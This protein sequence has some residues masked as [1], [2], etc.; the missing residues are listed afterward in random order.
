M[1]FEILRSAVGD[2]TAARLG[3]LAFP[4]R[5]PI[6]T[7]NFFAVTSRGVVPHITPDNVAKYGHFGGAYMALED[8]NGRSQKDPKSV[9][10]I[11]STK[12]EP[13]RRLL[14]TFTSQSS[15]LVT[16]LGP[17]RIPAVK[18]AV[19][20]GHNFINIFASTGFQN[21]TIEEYISS[22]KTLRP[23]IAIPLA[24][25]I[26]G[27]TRTTQSSRAVRQAERTEDWMYEWTKAFEDDTKPSDIA[28]FAPTLP[29]PY[30]VQWEY[31]NR[32]SSDFI[33]SISGLAIYD[34]DIIPDLKDYPSLLPL[35]RLSLDL[36]NSPHQ[37]LR[38]IALGVDVILPPFINTISDAG[39]ALTFT[40]PPPSSA[41]GMLPL[42]DDMTSPDNEA[43][44]QPLREGCSCYACKKHHRAYLNHLLNA[45][46]MLAWTLLQVHN[47]Q[48]LADFF[49][50][51]RASLARGPEAFEEDCRRFAM[52]YEPDL[53]AGMGQRP[54][55]RGYHFK[56]EASDEKINKPAWGK[57]GGEVD[58]AAPSL[59]GVPRDVTET[60]LI[61][62][63]DSKALEKE[64]FAEIDRKGP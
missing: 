41:N 14:H 20:N 24:D 64:G 45:R 16:V 12:P 47:H 35:P 33:G 10:P 6:E 55:A 63:E 51:I 32:V 9:A 56:S 50:D 28:V 38:Q 29:V 15:S 42:G 2:G 22:T 1:R 18:P 31:L 23:D 54:R 61:P 60:P 39:V 25:I 13:D 44:L 30:P 49:A 53:P 11:F 21:L 37:I 26:Y 57:F 59:P 62:D 4:Q 58:T 52:V 8:F 48:V 46:E 17:R 36:P 5:T 3:R 40:F 27:A 7:P 43:A 34:V 19:G